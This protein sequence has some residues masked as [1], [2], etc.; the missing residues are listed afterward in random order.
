MCAGERRPA[1]EDK[2][3]S[4][5]K[6]RVC[7]VL[8]NFAKPDDST[9]SLDA[10][11]ELSSGEDERVTGLEEV[12]R[13]SCSCGGTCSSSSSASTSSVSLLTG[14]RKRGRAIGKSS[15]GAA[16]DELRDGTAREDEGAA[17]TLL[18]E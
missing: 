10:W 13:P 1:Y 18:I 16:G 3:G 6:I 4:G 15:S 7:G 5:D 12:G 17:C 11:A 9:E 2:T 8:F 14:L